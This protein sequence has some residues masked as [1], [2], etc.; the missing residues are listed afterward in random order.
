MAQ[1]KDI[2]RM[3]SVDRLK[4]QKN[5]KKALQ[6]LGQRILERFPDAEII[7]YGS[8]ARGDDGKFSDIDVLV[9]LDR[10]VNNSLEEKIFSTAF[11]IELEC[12]VIFGIIVYPKKFWN[13]KLG[14][15]MPLHWN[16]DKEG[17]SVA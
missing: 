15:A 13:S 14:K 3:K 10:E 8:K 2:R 11:Q 17:I 6:E 16:V 7:L 5:E 12:D 1:Q 9:L 4:L